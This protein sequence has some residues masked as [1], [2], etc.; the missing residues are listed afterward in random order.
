MKLIYAKDPKWANRSQTLI[1]ITVRFEEI[2]EDLP[3]TANPNDVES[4]GRNIYS[5]AL[6]GE[7]GVVQPFSAVAPTVDAVSTVI[8]TERNS[9]LASTDW[10][11]LPDIPQP[12]R[13]LWEPYRQALRDMPQQPNFPWYSQVVI[14]FDFGYRIDVTKAPWPTAPN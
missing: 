9:R 5:R 10:T 11:Q 3:F 12:T 7:F 14:E 1:N 2:N 4:Y 13:D 8:K 6:A